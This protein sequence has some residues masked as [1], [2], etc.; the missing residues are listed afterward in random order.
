MQILSGISGLWSNI[1][2]S[3]QAEVLLARI[4]VSLLR[5]P[6]DPNLLM[7]IN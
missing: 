3:T 1:S 2:K 7:I 5:P 6:S 4:N